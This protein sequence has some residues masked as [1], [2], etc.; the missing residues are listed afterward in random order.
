[1]EVTNV[2]GSQSSNAIVKRP[3]TAFFSHSNTV[4]LNKDAFVTSQQWT[5]SNADPRSS[6]ADPNETLNTQKSRVKS[7]KQKKRITDPEGIAALKDLDRFEKAQCRKKDNRYAKVSLE[8]HLSLDETLAI[9]IKARAEMTK[10]KYDTNMSKFSQKR[11]AQG[12]KSVRINQDNQT[13]ATATLTKE[14]SSNS[15]QRIRETA[16]S[17][18]TP[19]GLEIPK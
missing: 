6:Y 4:Q 16:T 19:L 2:N 17:R 7:V 3:M 12:F 14:L 9:R 15:N 8:Q 1:M 18:I 10:A 13:P 11:L 5:T